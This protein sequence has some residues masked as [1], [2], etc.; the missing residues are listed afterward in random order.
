[1]AVGDVT[2][3][4]VS[5]VHGAITLNEPVGGSFDDIV[6]F[7]PIV[8]G[9]EEFAQAAPIQSQQVE[10]E[11]TVY[12]LLNNI[13]AGTVAT[14]TFTLKEAD[15]GNATVSATNMQRGTVNRDM[16]TPP[17]TKRTAFSNAATPVISVVL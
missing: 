12:E 16:N 4:I 7:I 10:A 9:E 3:Q 8:F 1:M 17:Y 6:Q 11:A 5:I 2:Y 14:L 13:P 15:G